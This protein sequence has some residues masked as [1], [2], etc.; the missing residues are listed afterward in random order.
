[1]G[2]QLIKA[3][4]T[5]KGNIATN[6]SGASPS[7][8]RPIE[9]VVRLIKSPQPIQQL[10]A[11]RTARSSDLVTEFSKP[12]Q[13]IG[14]LV[15]ASQA[16]SPVRGKIIEQKGG[17]TSPSSP[18]ADPPTEGLIEQVS[19]TGFINTQ[20]FNLRTGLVANTSRPVQQT[21]LVV[22]H[23]QVTQYDFIT[24]VTPPCGSIKNSV[25]TSIRWRIRDFGFLFNTS[26]LIFKVDGVPVQNSANFSVTGITNGLQ[27]DYTPSIPFPYGHLV[28]ILLEISDIAP[29]PNQF[30]YNCSWMTTEDSIAPVFS[31]IVPACGS[32]GVS[33]TATLSFDV[34][35]VGEGVDPDSISISLDGIGVCSGI[36]LDGFTTLISGT[37][38]HVTYVGA[39]F[40]H[41]S[42]ISIF[43]SASDLSP[44]RNTSSFIC[45]FNT[46]ASSPPE[47]INMVPGPC[48]TFVD[49]TTGLKFE[50]YGVE[51]GVDV[52]TLEVRIDN[53]LRRVVVT[54]RL[55][56]P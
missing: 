20:Q 18:P 19:R 17:L 15:F 34:I 41:E 48:D 47:F 33:T 5:Q 39:H 6:P 23:I 9:Q 55:Y 24:L 42:E 29:T 49:D 35:D 30:S 53:A 2:S 52:S 54:P 31:N 3:L 13:Q 10:S 11:P 22:N 51:N 21:T 1:M 32:S 36:S 12:I 4:V 43:L 27:L 26:S 25:N 37:G 56:R 45:A 8:S 7:T 40:N 16:N 44:N 14:T 50:V 38:Y 46:A 28:V